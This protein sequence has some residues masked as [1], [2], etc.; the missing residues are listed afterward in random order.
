MW[1]S[2]EVSKNLYKA[3]RSG[4]ADA[5]MGVECSSERSCSGRNLF[6][7]WSDDGRDLVAFKTF[8]GTSGM[9]FVSI[10]G[11]ATQERP[12]K[13]THRFRDRPDIY[14]NIDRLRIYCIECDSHNNYYDSQVHRISLEVCINI[15]TF[16]QYY[17]STFA[18]YY[19]STFAQYY[20]S[21]FAQY[22]DST[23]AQ[24]YDSTFAQYMTTFTQYGWKFAQ[25][26]SK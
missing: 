25:Y 24:Y 5:S 15:T 12:T 10:W 3:D 22:Y 26:N 23:F 13:Q 11:P 2:F 8:G 14:V 19:D 16:A 4:I 17:D 21:T 20:D 7:G 6:H 9:G 1:I 18:Q